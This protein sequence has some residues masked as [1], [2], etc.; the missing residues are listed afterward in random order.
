LPYPL[1]SARCLPR[2]FSGVYKNSNNWLILIFLVTMDFSWAWRSHIKSFYSAD[3]PFNMELLRRNSQIGNYLTSAPG[4]HLWFAH[5]AAFYVDVANV[6]QTLPII[7]S[8]HQNFLLGLQ[9]ELQGSD[10]NLWSEKSLR[11]NN[12]SDCDYEFKFFD[13]YKL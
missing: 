10:V 6:I 1:T 2:S 13:T 5:V 12:S 4:T 7:T 3:I 8:A 9:L 11:E